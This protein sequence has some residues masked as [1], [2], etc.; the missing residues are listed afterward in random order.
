MTAKKQKIVHKNEITVQEE[1][2]G[3]ERDVL[4]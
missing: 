1:G 2:E 4:S 3:D